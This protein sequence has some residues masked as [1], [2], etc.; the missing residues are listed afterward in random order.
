MKSTD[1]KPHH[2][3]PHSP[4]DIDAMLKRCGADDTDALYADV[5][6]ALRL[7]KNYDLP[8]QMSEPELRG[9]FD[10]LDSE[11]VHLKCFAGGGVYHHYTPAAVEAI[12]SRSEFLTAYTPYQP[13]V[14]QGTLQYIFEF[15]S[16]MCELT[17]LD[18]SNASLY[19]GTTATAEAMMMCVAAARKKNRVLIS[20]TISPAVARV[21]ATY[22][23]WHGIALDTIPEH[24]GITD[25]EALTEMLEAGDVA[26]VIVSQPNYYGIVEDYS[27]LADELHATKSLLVMNCVAGTLAT[28]RSPGEWGADIA[29]GDTQSLGM[30]LNYGGP[31]AGYMCTTKALMRKMPGRIV[32][33]TTDA[34][35]QR[36]FVLTLQAREQHIRRD[37]A[38][39]NICSNQGLMA[40]HAAVYTSLMG[41][42]GLRQINDSGARNIRMLVEKMSATGL[43]APAYPDQP[44]LN[45]VLMRVADGLTSRQII[46]GLAAKGILAGIE[47]APDMLLVACTEMQSAK[48]IDAYVEFVKRIQ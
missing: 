44:Y 32:G 25:R 19:D 38:T 26:G 5:P 6:A 18:V 10:E 20:A 35:G 29:V 14:S 3:L 27:G 40:L 33:A 41:T 30:P 46:D 37:K 23:R 8:V 43:M 11:N 39:S 48:D 4:E 15:Q 47:V 7:G 24:D 36:V 16:M 42:Q 12:T 22:A 31:Y 9:F 21:C 34:S 45:E 13:E 2:Y 1:Y 17:G 28:L